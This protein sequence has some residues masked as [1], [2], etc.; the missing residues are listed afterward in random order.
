MDYIE[1]LRV[2]CQKCF[3][4][5]CVALY[6]TASDGFPTNKDAGKPC[7]NL[8]ND[9]SCAIHQNLRKNGLKGCTSYECFGAGQKVAQVTYGGQDWRQDADTSD[10]MFEVFLVMRQLHEMLW[11]LSEAMTLHLGQPIQDE[12]SNKAS[13]I[14]RLS[15]LDADNL[16]AIDL[17]K[18]RD[19]VNTLLHKTS[20][21]VRKKA[22]N[23]HKKI[24]KQ[25]QKTDKRRIDYIGTDLRKMNLVGADLRGALL[26]ASDLRGVDLKGADL[27]GADL[28]DADI[29]S[30]NLADSIFVTQAQIN[31]AK[32][33]SNTKL[34]K[35]I[36]R[37]VYWDVE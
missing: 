23:D 33:D 15:L 8:K 5:C 6:F 32:G 1:S 34:P 16:M 21:I 25:Q 37:P 14:Y 9:F 4:Y 26:I 18:L 10:K 24:S 3:G 17:T 31:T 19:I 29:R 28:R 11:Y 35:L 20:E 30:A 22:Q 27:I 2:D 36:R 13:E 7:I 12:L